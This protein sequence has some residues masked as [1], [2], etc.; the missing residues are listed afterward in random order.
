MNEHASMNRIYRLLE[1]SSRRLVV[2]AEIA[3]GRVK[4]AA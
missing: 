4:P 2:V 3:R 1:P